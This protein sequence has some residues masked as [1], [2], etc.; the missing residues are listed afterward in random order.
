MAEV[1]RVQRGA[2]AREY[3]RRRDRLMGMMWN[4]PHD[5]VMEADEERLKLEKLAEESERPIEEVKKYWEEWKGFWI[6]VG[7][8]C[9]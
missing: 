5:F 7:M 4:A 8:F 9:S 2:T 6:K 1:E 3:K